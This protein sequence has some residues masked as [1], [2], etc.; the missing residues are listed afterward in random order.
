MQIPAATLYP[1]SAGNRCPA[2]VDTTSTVALSALAIADRDR[3]AV[4]RAGA[5]RPAAARALA[6]FAA[7][8]FRTWRGDA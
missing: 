6:E 2:W 3:S 1:A 4:W 7:G 5:Y 8:Y